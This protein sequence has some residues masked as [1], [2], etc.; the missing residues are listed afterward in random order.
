MRY[1]KT[2]LNLFTFAVRAGDELLDDLQPRG[3]VGQ[4]PL[5]LRLHLHLLLRLLL[6]L[7]RGY[8][9][10]P[11]DDGKLLVHPNPHGHDTVGPS[12][13]GAF[14]HDGHATDAHR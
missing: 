3:G 5:L 13:R 8:G 9:A 7:L 4:H 14:L 2:Y 11:H 1:I 12:R 6:L 10:Q